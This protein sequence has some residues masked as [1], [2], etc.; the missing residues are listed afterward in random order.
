MGGDRRSDALEAHAAKVLG[1]LEE[2]PDLYLIV[3]RPT[4]ETVARSVSSLARLADPA[5]RHAQ[6]RLSSRRSRRARISPAP[7]PNGRTG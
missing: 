5:R 4:D 1:R 2:T 7:A 6:K 3:A